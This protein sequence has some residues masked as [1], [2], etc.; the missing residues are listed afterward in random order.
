MRKPITRSNRSSLRFW[1]GF[2]VVLSSAVLI[3]ALFLC[4]LSYITPYQLEYT[5]SLPSEYRARQPAVVLSVYSNHGVIGVLYFRRRLVT[6]DGHKLDFLLHDGRWAVSSPAPMLGN[7]PIW[8]LRQYRFRYSTGHLD[9]VPS[10]PWV[11]DMPSVTI[12]YWSIMLLGGIVPILWL[13]RWTLH[14]RRNRRA[15]AGLCVR[16]GYDLRESL[17]RCPECGTP[18]PSSAMTK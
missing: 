7:P 6:K 9:A 5:R 16:C 3:V 15:L 11:S 17:D 4:S 10:A 8:D 12:P 2:A 14:R 18:I 1:R 13:T